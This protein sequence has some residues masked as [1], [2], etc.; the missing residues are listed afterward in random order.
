MNKQLKY[1]HNVVVVLMNTTYYNSF[2]SVYSIEL[3]L[4]GINNIL[5][6]KYYRYEWYYKKYFFNNKSS[7]NFNS[8][9]TF[10]YQ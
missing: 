7:S 8:F 9:I 4:F 1:K 2:D 6:I 5:A 10:F 3:Q